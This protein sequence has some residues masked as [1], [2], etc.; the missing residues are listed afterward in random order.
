MPLVLLCGYP[1]SGKTTVAQMI[2]KHMEEEKGKHVKM[3]T[4]N[5]YVKHSSKNDIYAGQSSEISLL[6]LL[7]FRF[8]VCFCFGEKGS[9]EL[10][11]VNRPVGQYVSNHFSFEMTNGI[12][13]ETPHDVKVS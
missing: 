7:P 2:K 5:D 12:F 1:S 4:E 6:S 8:F 11:T 10:T 13:S 3:L 9:F